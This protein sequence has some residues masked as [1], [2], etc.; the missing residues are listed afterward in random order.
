MSTTCQVE[1]H[2]HL[3]HPRI[4]VAQI[5]VDLGEQLDLGLETGRIQ[6]IVVDVKL[7]IRVR[8]GCRERSGIAAAHRQ[9]RIR[10]TRKRRQRHVGRMRIPDRV[11]L[12]R[13]Q[14]K[15]LAR[16]VG[17][18]LQPAVVEGER[19]GLAILQKQFAIVS[20]RQSSCHF[21]PYGVAVEIG[22]VEKRSRGGICHEDSNA[23]AERK[24][25]IDRACR[26]RLTMR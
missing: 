9:H 13:A 23:N 20:T 25:L 22:A 19:F 1:A 15:P 7:H 16:V 11:I 21:P 24:V 2:R 8:R 12:H 18:L 3:P 5:G 4:L 17:R 26:G 6:R 14:A 10:R